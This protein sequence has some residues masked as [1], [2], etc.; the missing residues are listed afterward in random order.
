VSR[1]QKTPVY[2]A[3]ATSLGDMAKPLREAAATLAGS[4]QRVHTTVHDFDWDGQTRDAAAARADRELTQD[5]IVA[6]DLDALADA[7]E[8][9][10]N[11][12]QPMID[13]LRTKAQGLEGNHFAVSQDWVVTDTYDYAAAKKT[14]END[15]PRRHCWPAVRGRRVAVPARQRGH[16]RDREFATPS[17]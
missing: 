6:A 10:K 7:Y 8:N 15:G 9:G 13:G 2:N 1:P 4:G 11:T 16:H 12:M 5:R 17:R 3:N 14:R